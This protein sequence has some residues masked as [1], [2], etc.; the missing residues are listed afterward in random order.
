MKLVWHRPPQQRTSA[1]STPIRCT[2]PPISVSTS[3]ESGAHLDSLVVQPKFVWTPTFEPNLRQKKVHVSSADPDALEL[4]TIIRVI[5]PTKL[6]RSVYPF[7]RLDRSCCITTND[8]H[9][10]VF[11]AASP[12]ERNWLVSALKTMVARLASIIIVRDEALLLEFFSPYAGMENLLDEGD[13]NRS[14]GSIPD[15]QE[16]STPLL[17]STTHADRARLWGQR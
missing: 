2:L 3:F 11:E 12:E 6:D 17:M 7:A 8:D 10:Y 9:C 15:R 14:Q 13:E 5:K 1:T 16:C 4:L